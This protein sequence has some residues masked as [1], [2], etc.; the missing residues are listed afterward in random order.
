[1]RKGI[2]RRE[3]LQLAA[4]GSA[5]G[6]SHP[7]AFSFGPGPGSETKIISPGCR[8]TKVKAARI[9]MG[10]SHGL[11][12]KPNL[13]FKEE[14]R[15]YESEFLKLKDELSDV[16]FVVDELITT[17]EQ[18]APLKDK[19][20]SVDGILA[21]HFNIGIGSILNEILS[22]GQPTIVFA[23]PYSGH[24]W[25]GFGELRKQPLGAKL[26][27]IL[28]S[29]YQ[30][31][32]AA[33]RPFRAIHHLREAKIL[34]LTTRSFAPYAADIKKKFGT[35][36]VPIELQR[37][38]EAYRAVNDGEAQKETDWWISNAERVVE[39]SGEDIF[40]SCKLALAFEKLLE[41]ETAT[42]VTVDCYGTMWDLSLIHISEPTRPY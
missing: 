22:L 23:V 15:F 21:I 39:P 40:K 28:S 30:Q 36:I 5:L 8:K 26:E 9:Y 6:L 2:K 32:A 41:E 33:I 7:R 17:P 38:V 18:V 16:D 27:C 1:M 13:N 34:N 31:L 11:W 35:E 14:I 4:A 42:V 12:P 37:V 3:F 20:K 10:T 19:L 24:E 29:D 25:V